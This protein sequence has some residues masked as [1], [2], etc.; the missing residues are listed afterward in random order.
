MESIDR[1]TTR[2]DALIGKTRHSIDFLK[3]RRS[4]FIAAAVTGQI[5][6][7]GDA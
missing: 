5:D 3:E 4:A 7:R 6:L 1:A 2:I